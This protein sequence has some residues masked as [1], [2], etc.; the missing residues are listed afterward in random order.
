MP[1]LIL[2]E[3]HS[4]LYL[5][6]SHIIHE[7]YCLIV[8][9][10]N[11]LIIVSKRFFRASFVSVSSF[12]LYSEI[13]RFSLISISSPGYD[14]LTTITT[15]IITVVIIIMNFN[16]TF[17]SF[18]CQSK[19]VAFTSTSC[20]LFVITLCLFQTVY[21]LCLFC[22]LVYIQHVMIIPT[23]YSMDDFIVLSDIH[24]LLRNSICILHDVF[25]IIFQITRIDGELVED[26]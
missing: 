26:I 11:I 7:K 10:R 2:K 6:K 5:I 15:I 22:Y 3:H 8:L 24:P 23:F 19:Q 1:E 18:L 20:I 16:I 9:A 12:C 25:L 13:W 17:I 14:A 21:V 4:L